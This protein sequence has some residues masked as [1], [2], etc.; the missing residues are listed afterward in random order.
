MR[1]LG[2]TKSLLWGKILD[3][4]LVCLVGWLIPWTL[5]DFFLGLSMYK[6]NRSFCDVLILS[7]ATESMETKQ[8]TKTTKN[9]SIEPSLDEARQ[10]KS[11]LLSGGWQTLWQLH[12]FSVC[13][14]R[15]T[16]PTWALPYVTQPSLPSTHHLLRFAMS[17]SV[18][19]PCLYQVVEEQDAGSGIL[20]VRVSFCQP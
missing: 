12:C 9:K 1:G 11:W 8:E 2:T 4:N 10:G 15:K 14:R 3:W 16:Y 5:L 7:L 13:S 19:V 6:Y 20:Y 18:P 17:Q